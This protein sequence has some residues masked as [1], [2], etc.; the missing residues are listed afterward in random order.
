MRLGRKS[1]WRA[2]AAAALLIISCGLARAEPP[3]AETPPAGKWAQLV[4]EPASTTISYRVVGWPH[5]TEGTFKLKSGKIRLDPAS[6]RMD[7]EIVIDATSGNSGHNLRDARMRN[8]ILEAA[9]F[10]TITFAPR[11]VVSHGEPQG[12]FPVAVRGVM[13]LRGAP[14][15]ITIH[16]FVRHDGDTVV[17]HCAFA[18][19]YVAWGLEDPSILFFKVRKAVEIAVSA[20]ARLTWVSP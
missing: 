16:G 2:I 15:P 11:Q 19:P 9:K 4:F 18:V 8:D 5:I 1:G 12:D 7:G 14:H 10:P 3:A 6:A 17:I 20:T 13:T